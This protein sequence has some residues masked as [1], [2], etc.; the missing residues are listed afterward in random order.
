MEA[1]FENAT[2]DGT[3]PGAVLMASDRTGIPPAP[4]SSPFP[5]VQKPH[6]SNGTSPT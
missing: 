4:P 6:N 2:Q 5:L 3:I 1:A